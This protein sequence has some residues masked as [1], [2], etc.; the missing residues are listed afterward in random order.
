M[1]HESHTKK[2]SFKL[3]SEGK[4]IAEIA[5]ERSLTTQTIEGHL[6]HFVATGELDVLA[7]ISAEKLQQIESLLPSYSTE[8]SLSALKE[9]VGEAVSYSELKLFLAYKDAQKLITK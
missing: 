2:E 7:L 8:E 1:L 9:K 4:T 5:A 3:F 6:S